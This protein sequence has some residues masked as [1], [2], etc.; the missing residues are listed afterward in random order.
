MENV[1]SHL[2]IPISYTGGRKITKTSK[3]FYHN[4]SMINRN[5]REKRIER[6]MGKENKLKI[7][8]TTQ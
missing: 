5:N 6:E 4:Y 3:I 2:P 7:N 8:R 1:G